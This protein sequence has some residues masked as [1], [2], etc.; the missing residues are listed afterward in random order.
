MKNNEKYN[1]EKL[2]EMMSKINPSFKR[3]LINESSFY[4]HPIMEDG[5]WLELKKKAKE[6]YD[7]DDIKILGFN[8]KKPQLFI[9]KSGF[10]PLLI[11]TIKPEHKVYVTEPN[12]YEYIT[13]WILNDLLPKN[14]DNFQEKLMRISDNLTN[15]QKVDLIYKLI[16]QAS[17]EYSKEYNNVYRSDKKIMSL[18]NKIKKKYLPRL[19]KLF[20]YEVY[21]SPEWKQSTYGDNYDTTYGRC[22]IYY[23]NNKPHLQDIDFP[24][25]VFA[26]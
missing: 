23:I 3:R 22:P 5:Y 1:K 21:N 9:Y 13:N 4:N 8:T 24:E 18:Q 6:K 25:L 17:D 2:F 19:E 20:T 14:I 16:D 26:K 12:Y 10:K 11:W 7:V 15:S